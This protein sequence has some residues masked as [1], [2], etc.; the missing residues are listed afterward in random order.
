MSPVHT[1]IPELFASARDS[2]VAMLLDRDYR[3]C[4]ETM[5]ATFGPSAAQRADRRAREMQHERNYDGYDIW[6][7]VAATIREIEAENANAQKELRSISGY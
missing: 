1:G 6:I 3:W 4:A 7:R 5:L 2:F